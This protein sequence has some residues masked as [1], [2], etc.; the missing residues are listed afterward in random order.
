MEIVI[1][2]VSAADRKVWL[3][4]RRGIWPDAEEEYL[5]FDMDDILSSSRDAV[6]MAFADG[7]AAGM[8]EVRLRDYCEGCE[9]GP[10]GYIEAWFV[11]AQF[12]GQGVAAELV[13]TGEDWARE[14]GCTEMGSDTW[15]DNGASIHAHLKLGFYEAERLVHFVK[16]L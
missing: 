12:R 8:I 7:A 16:Q 6:F 15:L 9:T 1:Q 5:T 2:R 10:V 4:M 11:H 14:Q 13:R 3:D